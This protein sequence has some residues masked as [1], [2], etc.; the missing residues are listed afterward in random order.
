MRGGRE[1]GVQVVAIS[2]ALAVVYSKFVR[3][4]SR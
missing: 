1:G 3:F 4:I 2:A